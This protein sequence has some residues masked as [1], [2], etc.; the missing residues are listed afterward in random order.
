MNIDIQDHSAEVSAEIKAALLRG[1]EKV[2][3]V[4]EAMRK[5]RVPLTPAICGTALGTCNVNMISCFLM[6]QTM[7]DEIMR[8]A[9]VILKHRNDADPVHGW[10]VHCKRSRGLIPGLFRI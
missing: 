2:G 3:L 10:R 5:S 7:N 8:A 4:A 6:Q 9:E 1:L